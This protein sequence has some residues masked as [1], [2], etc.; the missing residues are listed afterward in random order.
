MG[1]KFYQCSTP[2]MI[3]DL[4]K[5][6][7]KQNFAALSVTDFPADLAMYFIINGAKSYANLL[8]G[9]EQFYK[10]LNEIRDGKEYISPEVQNRIDIRSNYPEP[11]GH[12]TPKQIEV[13]RLLANG[14]T[15]KE[16]AD[17]LHISERTVDTQKTSLYT[18]LNVRNENEAVRAALFLGIIKQDEM[19]FFGGNYTLNPKPSKQNTKNTKRGRTLIL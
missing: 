16:I 6:F 1:C 18:A 10:G 17:V 8:E 19:D 2:F 9:P 14:F 15:G 13:L 3:A 11:S 7:P 12:L 5:L 4:H